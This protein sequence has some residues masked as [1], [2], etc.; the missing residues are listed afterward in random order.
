MKTFIAT[1]VH[2]KV[3]DSYEHV[4]LYKWN[5]CQVIETRKISKLAYEEIRVSMAGTKFRV[6]RGYK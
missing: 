4:P 5:E 1:V 3:G 6:I 2:P